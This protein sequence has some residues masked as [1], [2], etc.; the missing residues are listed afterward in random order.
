M[1]C[2]T[3]KDTVEISF[4]LPVKDTSDVSTLF[5]AHKMRLLGVAR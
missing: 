3:V 4:A 1:Y 5:N 2:A